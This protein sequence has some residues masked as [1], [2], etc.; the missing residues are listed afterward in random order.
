MYSLL[1]HYLPGPWFLKLLIVLGLLA[2]VFFGLMEFVFP[3]VS[4]LMPYNDVAF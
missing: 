3:W 2:V 4:T 1:W